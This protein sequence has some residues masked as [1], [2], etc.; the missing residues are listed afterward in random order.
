MINE[1]STRMLPIDI[2]LT[3]WL[4]RARIVTN[5]FNGLSFQTETVE[6]ALIARSI[7]FHRAEATV[8]MR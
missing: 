5:R 7:P 8:L 2:S 1:L 4:Q 3:P 6:T